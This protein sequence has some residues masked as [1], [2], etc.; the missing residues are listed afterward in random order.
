MKPRYGKCLAGLATLLASLACHADPTDLLPGVSIGQ[1]TSGALEAM[2]AWCPDSTIE[3]FKK[4]SFPLAAENERWAIFRTCDDAPMAFETLAM[5][6][7]D[8]ALAHLEAR[9]IDHGA[10]TA[11]LGEPDGVYLGMENRFDGTV[12][13]DQPGQ[14]L[15]W[16]APDAVHPNLFAW[17]SPQLDPRPPAPKSTLIPALLDFSSNLEALRPDFDSTCGQVSILENERVWLPNQ[18]EQQVQIDCFGLP[19]AGFERKIEAVFGDGKLQVIWVL[20]GKAEEA[21]LRDQL[22]EDWGAP[23]LV[24]ETWEVFGQGRISLRKDKPELL[25]LSDE[26]IPLY[27]AHFEEG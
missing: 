1:S 23:S 4:P 14:R 16:L 5:V 7:A 13:V 2:N 17:S 20:T 18:P 22:E 26:M 19:Y 25:I 27:S 12:W 11:Q 15:V 8:G 9:G 21:R 24:N 3:E 10:L 6:F